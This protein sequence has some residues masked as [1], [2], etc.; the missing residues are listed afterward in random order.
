MSGGSMNYLCYAVQD[1]TF[2]EKTIFRKALRLHLIK[3]AEALRAV[4]WNDSGDGAENEDFLIAKV[5][6]CT[7]LEE[8]E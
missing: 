2:E 8:S 7:Q 6:G 4:E 3:L 5:L 1:A